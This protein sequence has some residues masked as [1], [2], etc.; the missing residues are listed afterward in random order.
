[1]SEIK[2]LDVTI[3]G[4]EFRVACPVDEEEGLLQAVEYLDQRMKEIQ[5][6]GKIVGVERIAIMAALNITHEFLHLRVS[7]DIDLGDFKRRL[8][9]MQASVDVALGTQTELF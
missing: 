6:T 7:P 2:G 3:L 8:A 4:R 1:M 9:R 5:S